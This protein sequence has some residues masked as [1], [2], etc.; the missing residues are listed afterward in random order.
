M[1]KKNRNIRKAAVRAGKDKE[2]EN[3]NP[4]GNQ[5]IQLVDDIENCR[6]VVKQLQLYV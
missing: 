1:Y 5:E 3:C 2:L 6:E 4:W